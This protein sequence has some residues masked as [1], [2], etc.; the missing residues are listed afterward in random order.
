VSS[1]TAVAAT[2]LNAAQDGMVGRDVSANNSADGS[3]GFSFALVPNGAGGN[4]TVNECVKDNVTGLVWE[5][6]T[7]GAYTATNYRTSQERY[8]N[9]GVGGTLTTDVSTYIQKVNADGLCG[10]SDWRLPT[11][12]ELHSLVNYGVSG[13]PGVLSIDYLTWF[14]GPPRS[15]VTD[16]TAY[17]T[18]TS[19]KPVPSGV[20]TKPAFKAVDFYGAIGGGG[21]GSIPYDSNAPARLVRGDTASITASNRYTVSTDGTEVADGL[22]G[23]TW[24]RCVEGQSWNGTACT[25]T[26]TVFSHEQALAHAK[27]QSGWKVP[28]IKELYSIVKTDKLVTGNGQ[29]VDTTAFPNQPFFLYYWSSTPVAYYWSSDYAWLVNF[30]SGDVTTYKRDV[31]VSSGYYPVRLVK[32]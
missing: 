17:W 32:Q 1:C 14:P 10:F 31:G 6:K 20:T 23:L 3:N 26:A 9:N 13:G 30:S 5:G 19:A 2:G 25:G 7:T 16:I 27:T 12:A 28:N 8:T 11:V 15:N 21:V 29:W 24:R 18:S 22:T 4:Y